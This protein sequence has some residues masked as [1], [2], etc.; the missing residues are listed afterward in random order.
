MR[1]GKLFRIGYFASHSY[2]FAYLSIWLWHYQKGLSWNWKRIWFPDK[3]SGRF[4][5]IIPLFFSDIPSNNLDNICSTIDGDN[6]MSSIPKKTFLFKFEI[7]MSAMRKFNT[8]NSVYIINCLT[9]PSSTWLY[10][11]YQ[12]EPKCNYFTTL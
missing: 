6:L 5:G 10:E 4:S 2:Y 1:I 9:L 11:P 3:Q 8:S 12:N 7:A